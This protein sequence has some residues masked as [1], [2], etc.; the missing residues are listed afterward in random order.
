MSIVCP[1]CVACAYAAGQ[2]EQHLLFQRPMKPFWALLCSVHSWGMKLDGRMSATVLD[3]VEI[4]PD[5]DD[6]LS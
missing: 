6:E 5:F 3:E 4:D 1:I 2:V